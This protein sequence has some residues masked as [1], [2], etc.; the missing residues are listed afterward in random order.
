VGNEERDKDDH[1]CC[2]RYPEPESFLAE[3]AHRWRQ[4]SNR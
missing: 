3:G 1:D 4:Y 2:D